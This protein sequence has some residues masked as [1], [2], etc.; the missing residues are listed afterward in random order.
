[1]QVQTQQGLPGIF[2][3]Q[4]KSSPFSWV[5]VIRQTGSRSR[6]STGPMFTETDPASLKHW[7]FLTRNELE[8]E[9]TL[10]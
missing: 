4:K 1:M 9:L 3:G 10:S 5:D 6:T 8:K 2:S 7:G